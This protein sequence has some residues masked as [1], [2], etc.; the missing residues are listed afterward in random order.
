MENK[1][2]WKNAINEVESTV[3]YFIYKL[4]DVIIK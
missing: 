3:E 4:R 1:I 2:F